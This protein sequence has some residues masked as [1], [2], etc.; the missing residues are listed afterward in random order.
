[1]LSGRDLPKRDMGLVTMQV[2]DWDGPIVEIIFQRPILTER[3]VE[4]LL[5]DAR[6]FMEQHVVSA[7]AARAYFLTCYDG[8]SVSRDQ[9]HRLQDA[10]VSF[11]AV[12]SRGDARYGGSLVAQTL[13]IA[14][15]VRSESASEM[16]A[17]RDAAL[18]RLRARIL[19]DARR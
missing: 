19:S 1:M 14:T 17:T 2:V 8:F 9:A 7:G 4:E 18:V 15:A 13:V 11:N 3:H 10:F 5:W 16:H 12:Y 6:S